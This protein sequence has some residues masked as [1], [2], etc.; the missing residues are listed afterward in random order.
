MFSN[1]EKTFEKIGAEVNIVFARNQRLGNRT[2][3]QPPAARLNIITKDRKELF[4]IA[5]QKDVLNK[6]ELSIL[7]VQPKERHLVLLAKQLDDNGNV[8][9]KDHFLCG[10]DER[11]LFVASVGS[12]S[13]VAAAKA[14]LKPPEIIDQEIGLNTK[15]R[16]RRK[17]KIFKRQ[18]EWFFIPANIDPDPDLIR[19]DEP[20][21]RGRG[22]KPHM[23]QFAYRAGGESV[24]VCRQHPNGLTQTEYTNLIERSPRAKHYIWRDM[25]RNALVYVKGHVR[26]LDHATLTLDSWHRVLMNTERRTDA[27]AF[28]D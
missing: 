4:E 22:S 28:L 17:T 21:V 18:G 6:L 14:S 10:H 5:I 25:Q 16:N 24:K 9:T 20:L 3:E 13:T 2:D 8:I 11:H 12:V 27:V 7:E 1:L 15:K 26:H 19:K 23:A